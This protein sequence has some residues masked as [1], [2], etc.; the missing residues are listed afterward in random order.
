MLFRSAGVVCEIGDMI[1]ALI[2]RAGSG[3]LNA[4]W[5]VI[6]SNIDGAVIGPASAV[7]GNLPKFNGVT[8]KL[9]ADGYSV[10][11]TLSSSTT[12][13]PR[14]DAVVAAIAA[15]TPAKRYSVNLTANASQ[16]VT[17]NLG[18]KDLIVAIR[19]VGSPYGLV[20]ADVEF[21]TDN[22]VTVTFAAA[23]SANQYRITLIG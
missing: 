14:A 13:I 23:P 9:I 8:G 12:A 16:T 5:T 19:E 20:I 4:D 22:T 18:T 11:T 2:D 17:H 3:N 7:S 10:Q 15:V 1:I 21:T 6:Q